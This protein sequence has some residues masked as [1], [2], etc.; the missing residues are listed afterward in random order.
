MMSKAT[1]APGPRI[2][3]IGRL[4]LEVRMDSSRA[5]RRADCV[6]PLK[7]LLVFENVQH[8]QSGDAS[9]WIA[10]VG[11]TEAARIGGVHDRRA[12]DDARYR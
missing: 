3:A 11:S 1:I 6:R 8:R 10:G 4:E 9:E 7:Q 12:P 2:A 5:L